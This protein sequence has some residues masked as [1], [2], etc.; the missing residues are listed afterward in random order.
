MN[1][2]VVDIGVP[3][4][5]FLLMVV[6]GLDL[7]IGEFRR[8]WHRPHVLLAGLLAPIVVLP[9]LA[10]G[11]VLLSKPSP[12]VAAGLLLMA[13]CPIGG[14]SNVYT[15]LAGADTALSVAL[16]TLSCALAVVTIP[17]IS[18]GLA[19]VIG[20]E[21]VFP[22]P[23][24]LLLVQ[25]ILMLGV[26]VLLGMMIRVRWS[27]VASRYRSAIQRTA[28]ALVAVL[29]VVVIG[30]QFG[31]FLRELTGLVPRVLLFMLASLGAGALVGM[32]VRAD[33]LEWATLALEFGTRN[34]VVATAIA[35]TALGR[36]DFAV[37]SATYFLAELPL[38][39]LLTI[40]FR[41]ANR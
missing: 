33:R 38:M 17:A 10:W 22:V 11:L 18:G 37:F 32:M 8:V 36:I 27:A 24:R 9:P 12:P 28:F 2:G 6:V 5:T 25:L 13:A 41:R 39:L 4:V 15:L 31:L 20:R 21:F 35:V 34:V 40:A 14:I 3:L 26:P 7:T 16:T 19:N 1:H 30:T 29:I 23:G